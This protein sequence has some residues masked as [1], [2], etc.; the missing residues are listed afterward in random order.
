MSNRSL[1]LN[2]LWFPRHKRFLILLLSSLLT[3]VTSCKKNSSTE[4]QIESPRKLTLEEELQN[5]QHESS[6]KP[7]S[8]IKTTPYPYT[9]KH[10]ESW[11]P[12]EPT[13]FRILNFAFENKGEVYLSKSKG[14]ILP[15]VNRWLSQ[16]SKPPL[17]NTSDLETI[18]IFGETAYIVRI[19]GSFQGMRMPKAIDNHSLLGALVEVN[20]DLITIKMTGTNSEVKGQQQNFISF[21]SSLQKK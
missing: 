14:G 7:Y 12:K 9:F 10:P 1:E 2:L 17:T 4:I 21:C 6:E 5:S 3:L 18:Q 8:D 13:F 16:F 15:N 19:K 20:G 11:Q